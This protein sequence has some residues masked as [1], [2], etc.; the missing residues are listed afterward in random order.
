M[1]QL[2]INYPNQQILMQVFPECY[3]QYTQQEGLQLF[4]I[5]IVSSSAQFF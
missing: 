1:E 3:I 2:K 4:P 5:S